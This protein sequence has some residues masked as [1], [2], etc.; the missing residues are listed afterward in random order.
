METIEKLIA[1]I[2]T[3]ALGV[4]HWQVRDNVRFS[5]ET[6]SPPLTTHSHIHQ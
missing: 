2:Q 1:E 6:C 3:A 5:I 4:D